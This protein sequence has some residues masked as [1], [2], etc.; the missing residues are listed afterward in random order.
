[1]AICSPAAMVNIGEA[2]NR[3][4]GHGQANG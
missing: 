1:M 3:V 4:F 2:A